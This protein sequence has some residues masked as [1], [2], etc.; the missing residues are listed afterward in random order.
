MT[1]NLLLVPMQMAASKQCD[2]LIERSTEL[3]HRERF[4]RRIERRRRRFVSATPADVFTSSAV[5]QTDE[6]AAEAAAAASKGE[7]E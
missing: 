6:G 2:R 7:G 4:I 3:E 5:L 1:N